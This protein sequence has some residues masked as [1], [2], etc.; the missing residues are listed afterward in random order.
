MSET[1]PKEIE[2]PMWVSVLCF[3]VVIAG[4]AVMVVQNWGDIARHPLFIYPVSIFLWVIEKAW[5]FLK[6][7]TFEVILLLAILWKLD[8]ISDRL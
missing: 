8:Q 2:T 1:K 3:V 4:L 5:G 7:L 6:G